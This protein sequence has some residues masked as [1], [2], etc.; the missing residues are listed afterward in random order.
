MSTKKA[1][2]IRIFDHC[3]KLHHLRHLDGSQEAIDEEFSNISMVLFGATLDDIEDQDHL[4]IQTDFRLFGNAIDY[5]KQQGFDITSDGF[6]SLPYW[7][8]LLIMIRARE[9]GLLPK[10]AEERAERRLKS[11]ARAFIATKKNR[12]PLDS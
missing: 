11:E 2:L 9:L 8:R 12:G 6:A 4:R 5:A 10:T 7:E 3:D 1:G